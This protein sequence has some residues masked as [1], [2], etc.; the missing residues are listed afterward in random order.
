MLKVLAFGGRE[1]SDRNRVFQTLDELIVGPPKFEP[2]L[3]RV[4]RLEQAL[5]EIE[6][7][8]ATNGIKKLAGEALRGTDSI[9][10]INGLAPGAD[11]LALDWAEKTLTP[12]L[13]FR[14]RWK[15]F[16][17]GA[18]V[19]RNQKMLDRGKPNLGVA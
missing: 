13:T 9:I 8:A 2:L 5:Q 16:G 10:L 7:R 4:A 6:Q 19:I 12:V 3:E 18:G 11:T 14:P 1:Y 15:T 17:N